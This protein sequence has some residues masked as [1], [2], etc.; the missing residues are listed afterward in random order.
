MTNA[1]DFRSIHHAGVIKIK[2]SGAI[3]LQLALYI[4]YISY[5]IAT[6]KNEQ[7]LRRICIF[8]SFD[9]AAILFS[10]RKKMIGKRVHK[11]DVKYFN[12]RRGKEKERKEVRIQHPEVGTPS[13]PGVQRPSSSHFK[14]KKKKKKGQYIKRTFSLFVCVK[15]RVLE[16]SHPSMIYWSLLCLLSSLYFLISF[17]LFFL[18]FFLA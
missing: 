11:W 17:S 2:L 16:R 13:F 12:Q 8:P 9:L 3:K 15:D 5:T 6:T 10:T 1:T 14:K 7:N 4:F 18:V